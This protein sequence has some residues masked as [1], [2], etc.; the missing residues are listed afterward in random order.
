MYESTSS[1]YAGQHFQFLVYQLPVY[2]GVDAASAT[3]TWGAPPQTYLVG[4]CRVL[5]WSTAFS[6]PPFPP[7]QHPG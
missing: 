1:W 3:K 4:S 7:R 6:V 5:V 2:E